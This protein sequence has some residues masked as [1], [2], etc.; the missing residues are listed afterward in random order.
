MDQ[1]KSEQED[2]VLFRQFQE[3][4]ENQNELQIY[5]NTH[6]DRFYKAMPCTIKPRKIKN[7]PIIMAQMLV[8]NSQSISPK[9]QCIKKKFRSLKLIVRKTPTR[10]DER[11]QQLRSL[12]VSRR[13][14]QRCHSINSEVFKEVNLQLNHNILDQP[15]KL[16]TPRSTRAE[17]YFSNQLRDSLRTPRCGIT[18]PQY[19]AGKIKSIK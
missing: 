19:L 17:L 16:R 7:N 6:A 12:L 9:K 3:Y 11:Q 15:K 14:K 18:I 1:Q 5:H 8:R 4:L 2:T 10:N 13:E